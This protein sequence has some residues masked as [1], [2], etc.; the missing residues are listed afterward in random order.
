MKLESYDRCP[1]IAITGNIGSGKT[2]VAK[3]FE[4]KGAFIIDADSR[5]KRLLWNDDKIHKK[6]IEAFGEQICGVDGRIIKEKLVEKVFV[7]KKSIQK[8]NRIVHPELRK[9]YWVEIEKHAFSGTYALIAV[10]AALV[11]EGKTEKD[12]DFV[13]TVASDTKRMV[14]RIVDHNNVQP[15]SVIQ[16]MDLQISQEEKIRRAHFVIYNNSS[17]EDLKNLAE[18]MFDKIVRTFSRQHRKNKI[19]L[20]TTL[21]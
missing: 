19:R 16:R 3:I 21:Q 7:N 12:Y 15:E 17:E 6:V 11:F 10:D 1:I 20:D 5:A 9:R 14:Q 2:A 8:L 4:E 18:D 13:V